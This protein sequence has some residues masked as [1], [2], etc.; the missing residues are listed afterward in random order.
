MRRGRSFMLVC[1]GEERDEALEMPYIPRL[2]VGRL[3]FARD[4]VV[5]TVRRTFYSRSLL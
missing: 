3:V 4:G 1:D 5:T 2:A